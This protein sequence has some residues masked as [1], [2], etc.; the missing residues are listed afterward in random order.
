MPI[1]RLADLLAV[2]STLD[3]VLPNQ[4]L[5]QAIESGVITTS[6]GTEI[7]AANVQPASLDLRLGPVAYRLRCSFLPDR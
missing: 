2:D 6:D 4:H 7:P 1:R 5:E 3:G